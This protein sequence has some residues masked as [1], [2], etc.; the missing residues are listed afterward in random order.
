MKYSLIAPLLASAF[1]G[2][3]SAHTRVFSLWV[4][5]VDQGEGGGVY[6]RQPPSN[7]PVKD[8][9]SADVACNVNN[10]AVPQKV[11]VNAG[12]TVS[13]EWFHNT[14]G[15]DI[16]DASHKG[17]IVAYLAPLESNGEGNVWVKIGEM[18]Y[19]NGQWAV[20]K[21]I[22]DGGKFDFTIPSSVAPGDY[23]FRA[24]IL[25]LHEA[26]GLASNS[27]RGIQLYPSC[28]QITVATG[29]DT[30]LPAGV[31]FPG[32]YTDTT[33][34]IQ[35]NI[36]GTDAS[37]YV[38]PGPAV[39]DGSASYDT[40]QEGSSSGG[41]ATSAAASTSAAATSAAASTSAAA[42]ATSAVQSSAP[43]AS[44]AP[45]TSAAASST[46]AAPSSSAAPEEP[47]TSAAATSAAPTTSA[48]ASTSA[49]ATSAPAATTSAATGDANVCMNEYNQC[50]AKSQPNPD[51]T[52]CG[53]TRDT[54]LST[55]RYNTNMAARAK[56]DGKFGRLLL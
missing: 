45:A 16:I 23:L 56:R 15:D 9:T 34:G 38:I 22:A 33:P 49:A 24:E 51:W 3:V 29:G 35:F 47:S 26:D 6:I 46:P 17:P 28:S 48:A 31:A 27:A 44:S 2:S 5:G 8:L 18:G 1:I 37:T 41:A 11:S 14:R 10:V 21:L 40:A 4:D 52:G 55:A 50:I 43:A 54:C 20:E 19:E 32:A 7:S 36:Y 53:A 12:S 25:A 13:T 42:P 30:A 39:W